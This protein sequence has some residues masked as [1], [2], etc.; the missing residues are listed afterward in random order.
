IN[1]S[2]GFRGV[3]F[4]PRSSTGSGAQPGVTYTWLYDREG[5][6]S[7]PAGYN[8]FQEDGVYR[9][10]MRA[11]NANG[12]ECIAVKSVTINRRNV[13][14]TQGLN[15]QISVYPNPNRGEFAVEVA[16]GGQ[17]DLEIGLYNILGT[18]VADIPTRGLKSG[19]FNVQATNLSSG[20]YF[21]KITAAG[22]TATRKV[23]IQH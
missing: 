6:S 23:H 22:E 8:N 10:T 2:K 18:K 9:I 7:G 19:I 12:C 20:I 13:E 1:Y 15:A 4:T 3:D 21:V 17:S 14:E 11:R 5:Q 16:P